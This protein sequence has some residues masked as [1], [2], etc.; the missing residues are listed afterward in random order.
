M[1]ERGTGAFEAT[2]ALSMLVSISAGIAAA[3]NA[4]IGGLSALK[5]AAGGALF[6]AQIAVCAFTA[7]GILRGARLSK[8]A[9]MLFVAALCALVPIEI[10]RTLQ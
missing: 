5:F 3:G 10:G 8:T 7:T 2:A 4:E 6:A 9:V 1:L